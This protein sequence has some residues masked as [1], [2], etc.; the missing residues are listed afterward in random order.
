MSKEEFLTENAEGTIYILN[1][2]LPE[3]ED[4]IQIFEKMTKGQLYAVSCLLNKVKGKMNPVIC[5]KKM[6]FF[7]VKIK[8]LIKVVV[9]FSKSMSRLFYLIFFKLII[10]F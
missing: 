9:P 8:S 10:T 6:I 4:V 1:K 7:T 2:F 3:E 5:Q